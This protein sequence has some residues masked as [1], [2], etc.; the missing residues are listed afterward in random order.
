MM[1]GLFEKFPSNN[2]A[3]CGRVI[4]ESCWRF[5]FIG[6]CNWHSL[7]VRFFDTST[8]LVTPARLVDLPSRACNGLYGVAT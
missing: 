3:A 5:G 6:Q 1:F 4:E 8:N 7:I 2:K